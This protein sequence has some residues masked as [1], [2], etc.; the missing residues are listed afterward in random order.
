MKEV[1][2]ADGPGVRRGFTPQVVGD[3]DPGGTLA[4]DLDLDPVPRPEVAVQHR[5][6]DR[7]HIFLIDQAAL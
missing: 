2:I 5:Q 4:P 3:D 1:I 7:P 6:A